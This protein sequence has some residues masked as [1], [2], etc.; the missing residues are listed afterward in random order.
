MVLV[1]TGLKTPVIFSKDEVTAKVPITKQA[2]L[3]FVGI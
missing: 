1:N 2:R 3:N